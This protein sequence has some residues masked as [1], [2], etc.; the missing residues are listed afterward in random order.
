[1]IAS[2]ASSALCGACGDVIPESA[3]QCLACGAAREREPFFYSVSLIKLAV[4]GATSFWLYFVWWFWSQ[5]RAGAPN[6]GRWGTLL[7]TIFSG[8]FFYSIAREVKEDA[9]KHGVT[10]RYSPALLTALFLAAGIAARMLPASAGLLVTLLGPIPLL[11][12]QAAINRVNAATSGGPPRAW[13]W[14]EIVL[15]TVLGLFWLLILIG[16][17]LPTRS[18]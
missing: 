6:E 18:H 13:R 11:P 5:F 7:K 16:L 17:L 15:A 1:M 10:C 4:L 9:A 3:D 12:V 14:W 2:T 8:I